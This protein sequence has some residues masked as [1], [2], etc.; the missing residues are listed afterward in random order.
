MLNSYKCLSAWMLLLLLTGTTVFA[1]RTVTGVVTDKANEPLP[2]AAILLKG[3]STGSVTD[4]DG[5]YSIEVANDPSVLVYSFIGYV[6][7]EETVGSRSVIN[8]TL[9]E[10]RPSVR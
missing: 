4:M 2:G 3:T 8:K 6:T 9:D 5:K 7:A 10:M 1:Q